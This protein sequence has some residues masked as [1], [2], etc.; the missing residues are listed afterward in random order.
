MGLFKDRLTMTSLIIRTIRLTD[1]PLP[2]PSSVGFESRLLIQA[3]WK[4]RYRAAVKGV[5]FA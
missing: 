3:S 2:I 1:Y 5:P 4:I